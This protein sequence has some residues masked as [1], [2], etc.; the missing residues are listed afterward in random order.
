ML[1]IAIVTLPGVIL[2]G[3]PQFFVWVGCM[4]WAGVAVSN[5]NKAAAM[6]API[7]AG[8][9]TA[10]QQPAMQQ[11]PQQY[12]QQPQAQP[13][14]YAPPAALPQQTGSPN[15]YQQGTPA[16]QQVPPPR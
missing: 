4:V 3:I 1:L 10:P 11:Q 6:G 15:P 13:Q 8:V 5:Q 9:M 14:Q 12:Q 2:A 16:E 7:N